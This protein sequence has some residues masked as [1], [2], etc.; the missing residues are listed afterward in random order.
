MGTHPIFESDFDCL[1][2]CDFNMAKKKSAQ[3][4][5]KQFKSVDPFR[6]GKST[7]GL[8]TDIGFNYGGSG[9]QVPGNLK[10]CSKKT[11]RLK[12]NSRIKNQK[13][14][15]RKNKKVPFENY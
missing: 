2:V 1:T 3:R 15:K 10:K 9:A 6:R 11:K 4:R 13:F 12:N 7:Q 8:G 5:N 14:R